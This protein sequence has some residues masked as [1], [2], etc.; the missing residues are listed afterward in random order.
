MI[1]IMSVGFHP[2]RDPTLTFEP[3]LV[4]KNQDHDCTI[5]SKEK[6]FSLTGLRV[7]INQFNLKH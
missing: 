2:R 7:L 1:V 3:I 6:T 5:F 4:D